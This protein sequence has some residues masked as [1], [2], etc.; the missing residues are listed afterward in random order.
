[1]PSATYTSDGAPKLCVT[2]TSSEVRGSTI[3]VSALRAPSGQDS[4]IVRRIGSDAGSAVP[5]VGSAT[6]STGTVPRSFRLLP[7][8]AM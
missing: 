8:S 6:T 5:T 7:M 4:S 1:V 2:T 3:S